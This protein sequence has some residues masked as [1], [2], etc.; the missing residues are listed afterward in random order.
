MCGVATGQIDLGR[1]INNLAQE[2]RVLMLLI[3]FLVNRNIVMTIIRGQVNHLHL[4]VQIRNNILR[5]LV[6]KGEEHNIAIRANLV[7]IDV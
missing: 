1:T 7:M 5:G 4:A 2:V 6:R 3:I